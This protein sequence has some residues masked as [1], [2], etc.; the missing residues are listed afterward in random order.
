ML[1]LIR[2]EWQLLLFGFLMTFWS[3]P[4]Q[5]FLIS[6]FSGEIRAE[7]AL[8]DGE[9]AGIYSLATLSSA[10]VVI[11][12]G[13]LVDRVDL[14]KLSLTIVLGLAVGCGMMSLSDSVV[15]LLISLFVLRQLGQ[16]LMFI[17]SSTAMVRY[18]DEH[19]GK[20]SA[21]ASMG[22]AVSEAVMPGLLVALLLWVGWRQS[23]Q[24]AALLLVVFM[25][26]AI[27][28]LLRDHHR[29]HDD[30]LVRLASD[31][32]ASER[33]YRRR[34]WTRAE[35]IRDPWFYLFAPGL[36]SQPL[37]FTGFIFHQ[38][39]L[40]E[41][42]GWSL[43]AWASLFSLYA[44]VSVVTK[45]VCGPLIDRYGAIRMIPV[46]ALPMGVGLIILALADNLFWGGVFLVLTGI[47]VGFQSTVVAPFWSEM[48]G[49]KH[50]GAIKS[51]GA[52]AMV[53]CTALSPIVIGWQID[54]G[55]SMESLAMASAGY[56]LL[57]S[58]LA[59]YA[60]RS[61]RDRPLLAQ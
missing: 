60:C 13:S 1:K 15:T 32:A 18:L 44:L 49:N 16:G 8:S 28:Y 26:P 55:V 51:L 33:V 43:I 59:W 38:V 56:V 21:L 27:L 45:L 29:R 24:I 57:T 23:W 47:T 40:V 58:A 3:S 4:G 39:H 12:S 50:L 61:R 5:T 34:Q 25:V 36:M 41:S 19:K 14:K 31:D 54:N 11:W 35:V 46:I 6:L 20:A 9:F 7:L 37:M 48:Y 17:V 10:I 30:Y 2:S 42:K 53:F 22:Y 52:A